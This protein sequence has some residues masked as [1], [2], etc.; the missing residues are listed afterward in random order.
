MMSSRSEAAS[1][2]VSRK[3]GRPMGMRSA[4]WRDAEK[5]V[6]AR[7]IRCADR[8]AQ[9]DQSC[10][11]RSRRTSRRRSAAPPGETR[12]CKLASGVRAW[13]DV[14]SIRPPGDRRRG[15]ARRR[16]RFRRRCRSRASTDRWPRA[17]LSSRQRSP[18][19]QIRQQLQRGEPARE[20]VE[21]RT[22]AELQIALIAR[23][24]RQQLFDLGARRGGGRIRRAHQL[25]HVGIALVRHD[26]RAGGELR[27]ECR[28]T[29]TRP[30]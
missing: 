6:H 11:R 19:E 23:R 30:S 29:R 17:S 5:H 9:P 16:A 7:T 18:C 25:D 12:A 1:D 14:A 21:D 24:Q 15:T 27:R 28:R 13:R 10:A 4:P 26:R 8:R 20:R 2:N 3:S 22:L